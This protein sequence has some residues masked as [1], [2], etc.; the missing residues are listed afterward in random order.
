[1]EDTL[2]GA[3]LLRTLADSMTNRQALL[4]FLDSLS[5]EDL[6]TIA[7]SCRYIFEAAD[8]RLL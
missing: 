2:D 4:K 7:D 5:L 8:E 1:M 6:T 3:M